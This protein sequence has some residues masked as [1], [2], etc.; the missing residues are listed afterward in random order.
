MIDLSKRQHIR[1]KTPK[2]PISSQSEHT[3]HSFVDRRA[4]IV[5]GTTAARAWLD[6][7]AAARAPE[8]IVL[9]VPVEKAAAVRVNG[10]WAAGLDREVGGAAGS[11]RGGGGGGG[12]GGGA[13]LELFA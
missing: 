6:P 7:G 3:V 11:G 10:S 5:N 8:A 4:E 9:A 13:H 12:G 2:K 1:S